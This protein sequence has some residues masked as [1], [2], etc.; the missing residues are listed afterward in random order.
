MDYLG[1]LVELLL[2][3]PEQFLPRTFLTT[4]PRGS[5]P[6]QR[7]GMVDQQVDQHRGSA[8]SL[9]CRHCVRPRRGTG[10]QGHHLS[11][12]IPAPAPA[13]AVPR[14]AVADS[15]NANSRLWA[16][17]PGGESD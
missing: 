13:A 17:W 10:W 3:G 12:R 15:T 2:L 5:A 4:H 11:G 6:N 16:G 7:D 1:S 8:S 14:A 9:W